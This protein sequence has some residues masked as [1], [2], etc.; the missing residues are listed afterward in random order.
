MG[1]DSS[2]IVA[3]VVLVLFGFVYFCLFIGMYRS[4]KRTLFARLEDDAIEQEIYDEY[5]EF[6]T[7]YVNMT[8]EEFLRRDERKSRR[9][10]IVSGIFCL[11]VS[12]L[13]VGVLAFGMV[14]RSRGDQ[15]FFGDTAVLVVRSGSMQEKNDSNRYLFENG[16]DDQIEVYEMITITRDLSQIDLY[17]IVAFEGRNGETVVHRLV[18]IE[19]T[20]D[21]KTLY[22]FRGDSNAAS[23][24]WEMRVASDRLIGVDTGFRNL[25]LG[26]FVVYLQSAIGLISVVVA[27]IVVVSYY[28]YCSLAAK[29][30]VERRKTLAKWAFVNTLKWEEINRRKA[31]NETLLDGLVPFSLHQRVLVLVGREGYHAGDVGVIVRFPEEG[32]ALVQMEEGANLVEYPVKELSSLPPSAKEL[33]G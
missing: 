15:V 11:L 24:D 26:Q 32:K 25:F 29:M 4:R 21:G 6:Q 27:V 17:D 23:F 30:Y 8:F 22:S 33:L 7:D 31:L 13:C 10:T 9:A 14:A 28:I 16:L 12:L 5:T 1:I 3:I 2:L 18:G 19:E 20:E